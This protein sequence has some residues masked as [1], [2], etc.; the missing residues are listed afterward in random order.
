MKKYFSF[1]L[2]TE[3]C[4]VHACMYW[5]IVFVTLSWADLP[6]R[7]LTNQYGFRC[8]YG[9]NVRIWEDAKALLFILMSWREGSPFSSIVLLSSWV[10]VRPRLELACTLASGTEDKSGDHNTIRA[11]TICMSRMWLCEFVLHSIILIY[12]G[13]SYHINE[14]IDK[15][16]IA[17]FD[18]RWNFHSARRCC[19][20][21]IPLSFF[22]LLSCCSLLPSSFKTSMN[23]LTWL[24]R[25]WQN[26]PSIKLLLHDQIS[27][28]KFHVSNVFWS[29]KLGVF[30]KFVEK[31]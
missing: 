14:G 4:A 26:W 5:F 24:H 12:F 3:Y 10:E 23:S 28:D 31:F 6:N 30:D 13:Q 27:F 15:S 29:C 20:F 7:L 22:K 21:S 8:T 16:K 1:T 2:L 18:E 19:E 9:F 25:D 17:S 11:G